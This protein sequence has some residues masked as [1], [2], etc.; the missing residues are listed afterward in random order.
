MPIFYT[1]MHKE[2]DE[3]DLASRMQANPIVHVT[4]FIL[5]EKYVMEENLGIVC[6]RGKLKKELNEFWEEGDNSL[7]KNIQGK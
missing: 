2:E 3:E 6:K 4:D 1:C 7:T 5:E